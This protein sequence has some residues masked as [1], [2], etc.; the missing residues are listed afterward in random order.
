MTLGNK[1]D[2]ETKEVQLLT[3]VEENKKKFS[4]RAIEG[5][6]KA[7]ELHGIMQYPSIPDYKNMIRYQMI[8][9]CPVTV[10]D[11]VTM[12]EIF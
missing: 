10:E 1:K 2:K 5:A 4:K 9:N 6:K 8:K 11:V 7:Q 12:E 3:T